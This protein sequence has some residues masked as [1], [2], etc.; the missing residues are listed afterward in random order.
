MKRI[1]VVQVCDATMLNA[2]S[3]AWIK[4]NFDNPCFFFY[5]YF[6]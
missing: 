3:I 1:I 5:Y 6:I 2:Y 4:K